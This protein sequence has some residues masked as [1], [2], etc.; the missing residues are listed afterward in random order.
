MPTAKQEKL[1][2]ALVVN[3]VSDDPK[4]LGQT[5]EAV[6]Y[7]NSTA[8][9]KPGQVIATQGVQ[10]AL[11]KAQS[12]MVDAL[13]AKGIDPEFLASKVKEL[14]EAKKVV[15]MI[16][17]D[18]QGNTLKVDVVSEEVDKFA[19]DK[20]LTHAFKLGVGGGYQNEREANAGGNIN[21]NFINSPQVQSVVKNF[22]ENLKQ[23]L[24]QKPNAQQP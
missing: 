11:V 24:T 21:I 18:S 17:K 10:Q 19:I 13:K 2:E 20:G 12:A 6:G 3:A 9:T 22:E 7:S 5:L 16:T 8:T 15:K 4:T 14:L 1:A 23:I